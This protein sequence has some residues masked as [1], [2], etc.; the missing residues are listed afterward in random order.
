MCIQAYLG[1][2]V[3]SKLRCYLAMRCLP[4]YITNIYFILREWVHHQLQRPGAGG[5]ARRSGCR[6]TPTGGQGSK[7]VGVACLES[8]NWVRVPRWLWR[9][10]V[11]LSHSGSCTLLTA[12]VIWLATLFH[13]G[14]W[15]E[16]SPIHPAACYTGGTRHGK[17]VPCYTWFIGTSRIW[18]LHC[19]SNLCDN[20]SLA[21]WKTD[22]IRDVPMNHALWIPMLNKKTVDGITGLIL[23]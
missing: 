7:V 4:L 10:T 22:Q 21:D 12:C 20:E 14:L 9:W 16:M 6:D 3:A 15:R 18:N 1:Y 19:G 13:R 8:M 5:K 2:Y 17:C 11:L 23:P